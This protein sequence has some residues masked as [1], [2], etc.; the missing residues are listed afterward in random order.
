MDDYAITIFVLCDDILKAIEFQDDHQAEM[1][2]SEIITFSILA[3]KDFS[4]NHSTARKY[5]IRLGY[6]PKILSSSRLNRRVRKIPIKIWMAVFRFLS[7]IFSN[8]NTDQVFAVD[9]F[10]VLSCQKSR[11]DRR[12]LFPSAKYIGFSASKKKY[13]CGIKVHMI[14]TEL[15]APVEF[16]CCPASE[17]DVSVLWKMEIDLPEFSILYADGAYTSFELEEMLL[18]DEGIVLCPKR[19]IHIK[20]K[21]WSIERS[22]RISSKRQIVETAFSCI[23]RLLARS[24]QVRTEQGFLLRVYSAI[25]AYSISFLP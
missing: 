20:N 16:L 19:A 18:E 15:G 12:K 21:L 13:F 2:S 3:A 6:F 17:S 7:F 4:G 24:F 22:Q 25:L 9:S 5:L 8:S 11:I 14:V 10:P 1:S 23:T